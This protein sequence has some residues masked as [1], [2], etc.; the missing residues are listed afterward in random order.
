MKSTSLNREHESTTTFRDMKVTS[1]PLLPASGDNKL[2]CAYKNP[3]QHHAAATHEPHSSP[4][5]TTNAMLLAHSGLCTRI[6][7]LIQ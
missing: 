1:I 4:P 5:N 2:T 6:Y 3:L 7:N